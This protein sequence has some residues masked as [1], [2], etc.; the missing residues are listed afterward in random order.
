MDN[1]ES[2][3]SFLIFSCFLNKQVDWWDSRN[4]WRAWAWDSG[5][6]L[7]PP[8]L[9][10]GPWECASCNWAC[11]TGSFLRVLFSLFRVFSV[12]TIR[13][14]HSPQHVFDRWKTGTS[15]LK[16]SHRWGLQSGAF[17][18]V[19]VSLVVCCFGSVAALPVSWQMLGV[20]PLHIVLPGAEAQTLAFKCGRWRALLKG[21]SL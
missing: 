13:S 18:S 1:G 19:M 8:A 14:A 20:K 7:P 2:S 5:S 10:L 4:S 21:T 3:N 6:E 15:S 9:E 11:S 12:L 16:D 17:P